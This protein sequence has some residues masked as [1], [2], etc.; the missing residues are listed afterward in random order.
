MSEPVVTDVETLRQHYAA[1]SDIVNAK[2]ID[3]IDDFCRRFIALSPFL[4]IA[5]ASADGRSD[6][7]PRGDAPGFVQV[8]D[9][10]TLL[11]PDR[12]GNN[13][14]DSIENILSEPHV[15][16]LFMVPGIDETLRINGACRIV[17]DPEVLEPFAVGGKAPAAALEVTVDDVYFHCGK[18]LKRS[19]LWD[20]DRH[21]ERKCFPTLGR[22]I[23]E[24]TKMA[25]VD[26]VEANVAE[27][28]TKRLY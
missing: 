17:V 22:I 8:V 2:A 19:H 14:L 5:T 21:V 12:R 26:E 28:Y 27:S 24:Q 16:L 1:P 11:I 18:A 6:C 9:D 23:A 15:G 10:K 4:V 20:A 3:R 13:R 25:S 7:S